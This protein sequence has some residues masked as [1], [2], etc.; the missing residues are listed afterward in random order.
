VC[1]VTLSD[2]VMVEFEVSNEVRVGSGGCLNCVVCRVVCCTVRV[3]N[4]GSIGSV[5]IVSE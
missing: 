5:D 4:V 2:F 1:V 3:A